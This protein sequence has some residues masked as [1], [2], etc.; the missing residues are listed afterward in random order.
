MVSLVDLPELLARTQTVRQVLDHRPA[1]VVERR[2][3]EETRLHRLLAVQ[4]L[5]ELRRNVVA[6]S[7]QLQERLRQE[8]VKALSSVATWCIKPKKSARGG[9]SRDTVSAAVVAAVKLL[10]ERE[11]A[12]VSNAA[13]V[14]LANSVLV[15]VSGAAG[16]SCAD[17]FD[18]VS[19][20]VPGACS[21]Q[22]HPR[23]L[24][25][26][27]AFRV[28]TDDK[29][30]ACI[31]AEGGD[32]TDQQSKVS[33]LL[34]LVAADDA[35]LE[36][37]PAADVIAC[38]SRDIE[39]APRLPLSTCAACRW[40]VILSV[41]DTDGIQNATPQSSDDED[42]GSN[43]R[44]RHRSKVS[45]Q[46]T[47]LGAP[48][49]LG[50]TVLQQHP[51]GSLSR[52]EAIVRCSACVV[53]LHAAVSAML[54]ATLGIP[55]SGTVAAF[56]RGPLVAESLAGRLKQRRLSAA[57]IVG[58]LREA[59]GVKGM[60]LSAPP[61][62]RQCYTDVLL[63]L[64]E[65]AG[66]AIDAADNSRLTDGIA[67]RWFEQL[68]GLYRNGAVAVV[69]SSSPYAEAVLTTDLWKVKLGQSEEPGPPAGRPVH[70][71]TLGQL[72]AA[73]WCRYVASA[74]CAGRL[75]QAKLLSE[76]ALKDVVD[77]RALLVALQASAS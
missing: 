48:L 47:L 57:D 1:P 37:P 31:L 3:L 58:L 75:A 11:A 50:I 5:P 23:T 55:S 24:T 76:R 65:A 17:A 8:T 63:P 49:R 2:K 66:A 30:V 74:R 77:A 38:A 46:P 68:L 62:P 16:G 20:Q 21:A 9:K 34:R 35:R 71:Q 67:R 59:D 27:P 10:A 19:A 60:L 40:A 72:Q 41:A 53:L 12:C 29:V 42:E 52:H 43:G 18:A 54:A 14:E 44:K 45:T 36:E 13:S 51:Y 4:L 61:I 15:L 70:L 56:P 25:E 32:A 39:G 28:W 64:A 22:Q 69:S 7:T 73:D 6:L 33:A 26:G